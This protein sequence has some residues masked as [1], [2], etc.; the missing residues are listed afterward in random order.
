MTQSTEETSSATIQA[1]ATRR[2]CW[3]CLRRRLVCDSV[4][5]V[6]NRCRTSGIVCPGYGEQ[7]PLRWVQP[8]RVAIR[9]R[10][11][12]KARVSQS[13][14]AKRRDAD[15]ADADGETATDADADADVDADVA[16]E[17]ALMRRRFSGWMEPKALH[18]LMRYDIS[19]ENFIGLRA[20][21]D[22][23]MEIYERCSPLKCLLGES[24]LKLP[25]ANIAPLLPVPIKALFI[26][27]ALGY[28]I[29]N[30][31]RDT[32]A[33]VRA[34][35][36]SA[37]AFWAYQAVRALN[38]DMGEETTRTSDGTITGVLMLLLADQQ[39]QPSPRWRF[40]YTGLM[41]IVQLRGG[42]EKLW[43][44]RPH[45]HSGILT[46]IVGEVFSN[47]TSPS[48]D[49]VDDMSHPK[50]LDF[51]ES[52]WGT[53][54]PLV[55]IGSICP[56][57]LFTSIIF[58]NHLRRLAASGMANASS[59]PSNSSSSPPPSSP[60][61]SLS[62]PY[63]PPSAQT[64]LNRIL[65]FSPSSYASTNS[66]PPTYDNWHLVARIYQS[67]TVLYCIQSLQSAS[68]LPTTNKALAR[69][70]GLHY[71]RLLLDL[72]AAFRHRHFKNC[73]FWA[74]VVAG[75]SAVRGSAFERAFVAELLG[76]AVRDVGNSMP[77]LASRVLGAFW[78]SG[79]TGWDDCFDQPYLFVM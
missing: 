14:S 68:L 22:Y 66:T 23:N 18:A 46:W 65:A 28:Q 32:E 48:H 78:A 2:H 55:Y 43:R 29:H 21:Y 6:C 47:T 39:F 25:M 60:P 27:F 36:R 73:F 64:L 75:A 56:P 40:H 12:P 8:G 71:D 69:T 53:G 51:L 61:S 30:L 31:P 11:R 79:K 1:E 42:V 77:L 59:P 74:L 63:S 54:V 57:S 13:A 33:S 52:A 20:S 9:H 5:P 15:H 10:R 62:S 19:C 38:Q 24:R 72:K 16:Y 50:N 37:V 41:R 70:L 45:M 35:A 26:L 58:I 49:Q 17:T 3:E 7:R 76:G 67:A 44:E 34:H 4:R